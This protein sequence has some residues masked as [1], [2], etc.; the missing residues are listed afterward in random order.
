MMKQLVRVGKAFPN[1]FFVAVSLLLCLFAGGA[2]AA[3][4]NKTAS[5]TDCAS[6]TNKNIPPCAL[7]TGKV[8]VFWPKRG[9]TNRLA[10]AFN[11]KIEVWIDKANVG[12]V[13]GDAPVTVSVLAGPHKLE[14]KV[15]DDYLENIRPIKGQEIT[16]PAQ[17]T[18]YFQIVD[19]GF[20]IVARE[21][22]APTAQAVLAGG[23]P[24]KDDGSASTAQATPASPSQPV[25][26]STVQVAV[27][28]KE[29]KGKPNATASLAAPAGSDTRTPS[30]GGTIYL[31]WP[32]PASALGFLD[33]YA[34][35]IPVYLDGRRVG[36][37]KVGEYL[38][39]KASPGEHVL[40]MDVGLS[41]GRLLKK[42]LVLGAGATTH[43]HIENQDAVRIFEDMPE[44]AVDNVKGL[45]QRETMVQ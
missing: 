37:I 12:I 3:A 25:A 22:D 19:Q 13:L 14:L 2:S 1:R 21:L 17:K 8:T 16:V 29:T 9:L 20:A 30:G 18:L 7:E 45:T 4:K 43:F 6:A 27:P 24:P 33:K 10:R 5:T 42:D 38:A 31:Y 26:A 32:R 34:S 39:L 36:A 11:S 44:E 23:E 28:G 15:F 40:G 41:Y 35:D